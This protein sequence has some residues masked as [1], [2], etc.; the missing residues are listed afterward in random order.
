MIGKRNAFAGDA[1]FQKI[2]KKA[3][4]VVVGIVKKSVSSIRNLKCFVL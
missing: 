2:I 3:L 4:R 1:V